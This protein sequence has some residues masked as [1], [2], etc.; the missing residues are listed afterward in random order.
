MNNKTLLLIIFLVLI[1]LINYSITSKKY[2]QPTNTAEQ[3]MTASTCLDEDCVVIDNL[4]YPVASVPQEVRDALLQALDDEYKAL[5]TYESIMNTHGNVRP[6]SMIARAEQRHITSLLSLFDKYGI[7]IPINPYLG[8][9]PV[10]DSI[11][12]SCQAGV[13]AEIANAALYAENL[14]PVVTNYPDI[15]QVFTNLMN[16]SQE[17]HLVAFQRCS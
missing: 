15:T 1:T 5:A 17:K 7:D 13:K 9:I 10:P 11:T 3:E 16:A 6:F 14:L 4:E 2:A 8:N 12:A